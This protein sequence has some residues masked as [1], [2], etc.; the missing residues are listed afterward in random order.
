MAVLGIGIGNLMGGA[1]LCRADLQPA[2]HGHA[3]LQSASRARNFPIVR[4]GVLVVAFLFV[5]ANLLA[6]LVYTYLDPR[7]QFDKVRG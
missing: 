3:D 7:I 4:A 6:D 5:V 1:R 2:G